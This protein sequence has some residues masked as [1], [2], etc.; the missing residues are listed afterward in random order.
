MPGQTP[1]QTVGPFFAYGLTPELYGR[2]PIADGRVAPREAPGE[3]ILLTGRVL[4]GEGA[5]VPDAMIELWQADSRGRFAHPLGGG[6][7]DFHGFGRTGTDEEGRFRFATVKPGP[8]PAADGRPQAPHLSLIVTARGLLNHL[9]TRVYFA[10]EAEANAADPVLAVVPGERRGTLIA[11]R[12]ETPGG[13][14]YRL[15]I[16]LQ[17]EN[18]TV[19]FDL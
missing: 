3:H 19:F 17:G 7:A 16:R 14:V 8:V 6:G 18:E 12:E 10:D 2:S 5:A 15:D 11:S 13:P 1:S 4:D 9:F